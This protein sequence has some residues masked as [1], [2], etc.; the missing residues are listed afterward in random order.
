[1]GLT[2]NKLQSE[3][4]PSKSLK[5]TETWAKSGGYV[6]RPAF[7]NEISESSYEKIQLCY[8]MN[9]RKQESSMKRRSSYR[10]IPSIDETFLENFR[11]NIRE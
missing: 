4:T 9:W 1:M 8:N 3:N 11:E 6:F 2:C 7:Q 5:T 10:E